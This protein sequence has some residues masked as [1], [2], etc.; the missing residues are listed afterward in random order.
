MST[1]IGGRWCWLRASLCPWGIRLEQEAPLGSPGKVAIK[2]TSPT[3]PKTLR[4]EKSTA[5]AA[6]KSARAPSIKKRPATA[7][8][9]SSTALKGTAPELVVWHKAKPKPAVKS[10]RVPSAQQIAEMIDEATMDAHGEDEVAIGWH[11]VIQQNL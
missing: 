3:K 5:K 10:S 4:P 9:P 6:A 1:P 7:D 11:S 2:K 8:K